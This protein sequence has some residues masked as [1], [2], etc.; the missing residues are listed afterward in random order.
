MMWTAVGRLA[1]YLELILTTPPAISF[2][3]T[4]VVFM[5]RV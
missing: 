2:Y 3:R 1:G 4:K 5:E